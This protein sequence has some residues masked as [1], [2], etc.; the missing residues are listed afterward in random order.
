MKPFYVV[1]LMGAAALGGGLVVR[2]S[3]RPVEIT[4]AQSTPPPVVAPPIPSTVHVGP[5]TSVPVHAAPAETRA[6]PQ[7]AP[8][9]EAKDKAKDAARPVH[10]RVEKPAKPSAFGPLPSERNSPESRIVSRVRIAPD[11]PA[12]IPLERSITVPVTVNPPDTSPKLVAANPAPQVPSLPVSAPAPAPQPAPSQPE[13]NH[14][15]LTA[16][17]LISV[18]INQALSSN[19][20]SAGD[21]FSGRLDRP[22]VASGFVIAERGAEVRGEVVESKSPTNGQGLP[23]LT[24]RLREI[25]ASDGQRVHLVSE[26][27]R[28][29]GTIPNGYNPNAARV[30]NIYDAPLTRNGAAVIRPA[31]SIPFKLGETVELTEKR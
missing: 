1:L 5:S 14:A 11:P 4:M 12:V 7:S 27:W 26:P 29:L 31:T 9:G 6:T 24:I 28:K 16:G 30:A 21:V 15:T 22:L 19:L 20:N 3:D 17:M 13:S 10:E 23:E 2:Y 25:L 8:P 18:R